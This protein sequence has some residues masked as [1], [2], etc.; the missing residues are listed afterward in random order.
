MRRFLPD[1]LAAWAL[2][3]L[4]LGLVVTQV[5]TLV[6]VA[7]GRETH[8]KLMEFFRLSERVSSV[9]RAVAT[10]TGDQRQALAAAPVGIY[11]KLTRRRSARTRA[12][13]S[14]GLNGLAR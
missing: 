3:T 12:S 2:L 7:N 14:R 9:T 1:S 8:Q 11:R 5:S 6:V 10:A 13:S 4:I